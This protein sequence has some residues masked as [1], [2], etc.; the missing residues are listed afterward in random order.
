MMPVTV[1]RLRKL[2]P[3]ETAIYYCGHLPADIGRNA[4]APKYQSI[5]KAVV[6]AA[7]ELERSGQVAL[8]SRPATRTVRLLRHGK[9]VT[10]QVNINEYLARAMS[11]R[12]RS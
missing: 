2:K 12:R 6:E 4:D 11:R 8:C 5:L 9:A 7:A 3:G 10:E 1:Q